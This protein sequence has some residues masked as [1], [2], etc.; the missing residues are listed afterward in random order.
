MKAVLFH[1]HGG[2][3]VLTY[4][5]FPTPVPGKGEVLL[6]LKAAALNRL[7]LWVRQGWPGIKLEY[8]HI[9]GADGAGKVD[10][11]GP[12]VS[13]VQPGDRVLI[14]SNLSCG[15]C[16]FC[17][18]G[19]DNR[20]QNWG[21]LGETVRGTYAE[22]VVVSERNLLQIPEGF[23]ER[24]AAAAGLVFH[25][26]WHSLVT[27][28]QLKPGESVLIVGASG[29]VNTACIQIAKLCGASVI[30]VGSSLKKLELAESQGAD[31]LIDRSKNENWSKAV[32]ELTKKRGVDVVVDNVGTTY[33]HSF[34]AARKGGRI[35][36]V[37]NSGGAKI[38]IDNR[39]IFG[40]HLSLI[41]S[42]MG[43]RQDFIQVMSLI[44]DGKLRPVLDRDY[45]LQ[46]ADKAQAYLENG[47]QMGKVT[48]TI[49]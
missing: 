49:S 47:E 20:C 34:R 8:P 7:D 3:D 2:P 31:E 38:E 21:L 29:G 45:V 6:R 12:G 28:G 48:L 26:A 1:L 13:L 22:Y 46:D 9:P 25:T 17:I 44:F 30:V 23:D 43:T 27:R 24:S 16:E 5:E 42:T 19:F 32:F 37:G 39:Y 4:T 36:N 14:N 18:S 41:G 10:A 15:V 11:V 35:L 33:P 40:K